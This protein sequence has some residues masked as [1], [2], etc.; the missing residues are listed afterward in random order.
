MSKIACVLLLLCLCG[1]SLFCQDSVPLPDRIIGFPQKFF[2]RVQK[3]SSQLENQVIRVTDKTLQR[4]AKQEARLKRKLFRKDSVAAKQLFG[5]VEHNYQVLSATLH[6]KTAPAS[7]EYIAYVDTLRTSLEFLSQQYRDQINTSGGT[8]DHVNAS[9]K[10][11]PGIDGASAKLSVAGGSL[12]KFSELNGS[13]GKLTD[14]QSRLRQADLVRNYLKQRR[15]QLKEQL[16]RFGLLKA[17]EK[18]NKQA[19]YYSR[20][21]QEYKAILKDPDRLERKAVGLL[22]KIPAVKA[23]MSKHSELARLFPPPANYGTPLA[24]QGL[25]TR[26]GVQQL[27]QAQMGQALSA[28]STAQGGVGPEAMMRQNIQAAKSQF[29]QMKEKIRSAGGSNS[30]ADIPDFKPNTQKTKS[31]LKRLEFGTN[32]QSTKSN[33]YWP[34]TSD[35]GLSV[36]YKLS[37]KAVIGIGGSY[38]IGWGKDIRNIVVT[39]EGVG[40][41]SFIDMKLKGSFF[42]SGGYEQNYRQRFNNI[43]QLKG[44]NNWQQSGLIGLSKIVSMKTKLFKKTR[45]QLLWDFLSYEQVPREQP[46]KFRVGYNF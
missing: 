30:D 25:Q 15:A 29:D 45:L 8:F 18:Y 11:L 43:A 41:R 16:G 26:A 4:L 6:E 22:Q 10:K 5:D 39:H 40:L 23:F 37:D 21:I 1:S 7:G 14:L 36:G 19:Y 38:K 12:N 46:L 13:L 24:L 32:L 33:A 35:I 3:K 9:I 20:Q 27:I 34:V 42:I 31:F 2:S 44:V 28:G 17:F